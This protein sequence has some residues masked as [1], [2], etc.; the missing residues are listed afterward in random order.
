MTSALFL[1]NYAVFL[2]GFHGGIGIIS[3]FALGF[4]VYLIVKRAKIDWSSG[5]RA[6][7]VGIWAYILTFVLGLLIYPVFRIKV[8]AEYFDIKLPWLS[9]LFEIK[10]YLAA[11]GFF[12]ALTLLGFYFFFR[13]GEAEKPIKQSFINLLFVLFLITFFSAG[14][15][16]LLSFYRTI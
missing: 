8:R 9:G 3:L 5:L 15:G 1:E 2:K 12:I 10:E 11:I 13:I 7:L 6:S 4:G 14:V 16:F